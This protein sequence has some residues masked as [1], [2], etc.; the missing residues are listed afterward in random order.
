MRRILV[1]ISGASGAPITIRFLQRL[2]EEPDVETHLVMTRGAALTIEQETGSTV[3]QVK[4]LYTGDWRK[5]CFGKLYDGCD[6]DCAVFHE[7][8]GGNCKRLQ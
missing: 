6:G 3:E 4:A 2:E 5:T 7:N 1:G 8:R